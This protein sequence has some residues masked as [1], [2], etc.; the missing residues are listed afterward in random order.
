M[1]V[2]KNKKTGKCFM[3][4]KDTKQ[5]VRSVYPKGWAYMCE[6]CRKAMEEEI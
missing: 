5:Q 4:K 6:E 1:A 2:R 3:C